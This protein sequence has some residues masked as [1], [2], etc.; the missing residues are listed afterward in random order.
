MKISS[1]P[2]DIIRT[3]LFK[4]VCDTIDPHLLSIIHFSLT[5]GCVPAFF[6]QASVKPLLKKPN[7]DTSLPLN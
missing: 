3:S 4:N 7:L 1:S 5:S 6:K 2:L